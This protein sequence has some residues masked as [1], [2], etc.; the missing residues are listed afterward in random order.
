MLKK[1]KE[2]KRSYKRKLVSLGKAVKVKQD[3][4]E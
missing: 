3:G 4:L 2:G 1:C